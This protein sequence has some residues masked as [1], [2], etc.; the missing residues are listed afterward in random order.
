[1]TRGLM[2]RWGALVLGVALLSATLWYLDFPAAADAVGRLGFALPAALVFSGLWHLARTIAWAAC[3]P[4]GRGVG[5]A[6]LAR[7]RLAAEAFSYLTLRGIAGE[8]LK[9]LLLAGRVSARE[10]TA[11]VALE[12]IAYLVGSMVIVGAA[13]L[14]AMATLPLSHGWFRVFRAFAL[15]TGVITAL[16]AVVVTGRGT[17]LQAAVEWIDRSIGSSLA[18]GRV[19][20]FGVAVERQML[21][22]VRGN[23][24]R[25]AT[26]AATVAA[27]YACM[28]LEV[29][30]I[31]RGAGVPVSTAAAVA[32]ETFSRV[33]SFASAFIPA[34]LGA[35]EASS[36]AAAA[37]IGAGG[38]AALAIA[39]RIRGLFWAA[40]GLAIYP[41]HHRDGV[42]GESAPPVRHG[43][44]GGTL[45][46]FPEDPAVQVAPTARLAGLPVCERIVRAA[47]RAGYAR[48]LVWAPEGSVRDARLVPRLRGLERVEIIST[49]GAWRERLAGMDSGAPVTV[50]GAGTLASTE[51]LASAELHSATAGEPCDVPAGSDWRTTGIVRMSAADAASPARVLAVL[52]QRR[53]SAP[54]LPSGEEVSHGRAKLALQFT[55]M[56]EL[57]DAER[58]IRRSSYKDTDAKIARFNRRM[59]LPISVTLIRTPITANQLSIVLVGMGFYAAW[60]FSVGHYWTGVLGAL[61]SL[62][63][64]VL[65]GCD[66]E[67]AR[68]KF[69]ESALGCW[70]ET[71]GDYSYYIAIFAGLTVGAVHQAGWA[72][73]YWIGALALAG[74]L[75]TFALLIFLRSRITAGRPEKLHAIAKARIKAQPTR[76]SRIIWRISFV[77][78]RAAM[79]YGILAFAVAYALPG[80][81]VLAALGANIY[82]IILVVRL[83]DLMGTDVAESVPA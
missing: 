35:L 37:A 28:A 43:R 14:V 74:T 73:F 72:G 8:P 26:L 34:N 46:Y 47:H 69:Q 10:A 83:R 5:F 17:Y 63:A 64:S 27:A 3:F 7:V 70:I 2:L 75:M 62:A 21:D 53:R 71:V 66:G 60:L 81:V 50:V 65:D 38:G 45:L 68:L 15:G 58:A 22:L 31:L 56:A 29:W 13:S 44:P 80:I 78:T 52:A 23:P 6:H 16:A 32:A 57:A 25:L 30:A 12:R 4:P 82:W 24:R 67:I 59:S 40:L 54:R 76:W 36:V 9:V 39:R 11:A 48:V 55:T 61:L 41:R 42:G 51:L 33:A 79:P 77:A 49:G 18:A 20:R 1:M 19:G